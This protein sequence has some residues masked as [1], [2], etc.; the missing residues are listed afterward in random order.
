MIKK[1]SK[2]EKRIFYE[3]LITKIKKIKNKNLLFQYILNDIGISE[4]DIETEAY[5][6]LLSKNRI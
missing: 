6:N 1:L 5:I 2:S 4:K 3:I